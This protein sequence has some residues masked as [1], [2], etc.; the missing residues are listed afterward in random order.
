MTFKTAVNFSNS[1]YFVGLEQNTNA[2]LPSKKPEIQTL[3]YLSFGFNLNT[4][5]FKKA[6]TVNMYVYLLFM[7]V[8]P[9]GEQQVHFT[10][11]KSDIKCQKSSQQYYNI[12]FQMS[13]HILSIWKSC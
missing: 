2:A 7:E 13:Q 9:V 3:I 11:S 6:T 1:F 10:I 5:D 12:S 8:Y 4:R